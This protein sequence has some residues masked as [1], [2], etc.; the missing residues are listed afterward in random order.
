M[1]QEMTSAE[2]DFFEKA[3]EPRAGARVLDVPCGNARHA[4]E[5]ARRGYR[6]TGVDLSVEFLEHARRNTEAAGVEVELIRADMRALPDSGPYEAAYCFGNSFGYLDPAAAE[7]FLKSIAA[8]LDPGGRLLLETGMVAESILPQLREDNWYKIGDVY[9][10]SRRMYVAEEGRLDIEYTT[11]RD[12]KLDARPTSS[13]VLT[14]AELLR[15]LS[16]AGFRHEGVYGSVAGEAFRLGS[17]HLIVVARKS[18]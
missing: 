12:G 8:R 4:I 6:V 7:A 15:M 9:L 10:L 2:V 5:L 1:T 17:R 16:R 11:L 13:Y 3:L 14:C 18:G